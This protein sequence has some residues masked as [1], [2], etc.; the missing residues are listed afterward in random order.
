M[1]RSVVADRP[2][3]AGAWCPLGVRATAVRKSTNGRAL[4]EPAPDDGV[5]QEGA[6]DGACQEDEAEPDGCARLLAGSG[7]KVVGGAF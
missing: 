4:C 3:V 7:M 6:V 2:S 5:G 1:P